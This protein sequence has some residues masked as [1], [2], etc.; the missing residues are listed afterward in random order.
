MVEGL[1]EDGFGAAAGGG[2]VFLAQGDDFLGETLGFF[3][4]RPGGF[5]AFVNEQGGHEVAEEGLAMGGGA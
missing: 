5:D 2:G 1:K 3:R 4:F